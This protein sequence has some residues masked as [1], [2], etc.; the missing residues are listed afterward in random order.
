MID[1]KHLLDYLHWL[2]TSQ[3]D[4]WGIWP[5]TDKGLFPSGTENKKI[6]HV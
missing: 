2:K 1:K 5:S 4:H 3:M 6:E